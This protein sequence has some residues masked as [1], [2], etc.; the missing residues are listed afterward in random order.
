MRFCSECGEKLS[1]EHVF[2]PNCGTKVPVEN[3]QPLIVPEQDTPDIPAESIPYAQEPVSAMPVKKKSKLWIGLAI[4]A[5]VLAI[6]AVLILIFSGAFGKRVMKPSREKLLTLEEAGLTETFD[7]VNAMSETVTNVSFDADITFEI[8]QENYTPSSMGMSAI[9][10]SLIVRVQED[11]TYNR[12]N[13]G[14]QVLFASN[15]MLDLRVFDLGQKTMYFYCAPG[16]DKLYQVSFEKLLAQTNLENADVSYDQL[17][18]LAESGKLK[19]MMSE[20]YNAVRDILLDVIRNSEI[21]IQPEATIDLF[22]GQM[23]VVCEFYTIQPT[24][25]ELEEVLLK[26]LDYLQN[27][28]GYLSLVTKYSGMTDEDFASAREEIATT[29]QKIADEHL[30]FEFAV[31]GN[32]IVRQKI[33]CDSFY[34]GFDSYEG[35]TDKHSVLYFSTSGSD[36]DEEFLTVDIKENADSEITLNLNFDN[37]LIVKGT[38]DKKQQSVIGTC[39]GEIEIYYDDEKAATITVAPD[40]EGMMHKIDLNP[41]LLDMDGVNQ[42]VVK[43]LVKEGTGIDRPN[44]AEIV[45]TSDFTSEDW[46]DLLDKLTAPFQYLFY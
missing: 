24:A 27:S 45:D 18:E 11:R 30:T 20:D 17:L 19:E 36:Y 6:A 39:A 32:Q 34:L 35:K 3:P 8:K 42:F 9:F 1:D 22:E 14:L 16:S 38:L 33:I 43:I 41:D 21:D 40:A 13:I 4:G 29:A 46:Y 10:N 26:L 12:S 37:T 2:C 44:G 15:P 25:E 23:Q 28:D 7:R 5:G 31:I